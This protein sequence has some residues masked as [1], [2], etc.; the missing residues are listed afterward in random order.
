[1]I[2]VD[3]TVLADWAFGEE[4]RKR[5]SITLM[6][7]DPVW[8]APSLIQYELGNVAWKTCRFGAGW[9]PEL[10]RNV[11]EK[12]SN[13]IHQFVVDIDQSEVFSIAFQRD[14][15]FYDATYLW[16]A[17][18]LNTKLYTRDQKL[19]AKAGDIARLVSD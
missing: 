7:T 18:K 16:V 10:V 17:Q 15:S 4:T 1:M 6:D 8:V 13:L 14:L 19:V 11:L 2:V 12:A 9:E 3:C 5:V